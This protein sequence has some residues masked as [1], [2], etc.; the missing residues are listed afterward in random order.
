M[1]ISRTTGN[2]GIGTDDP[3]AKLHV[4]GGSAHIYNNIPTSSQ[5]PEMAGQAGSANL[6]F[7]CNNG[8]GGD[9]NGII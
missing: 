9:K 4:Q 8:P 1:R 2:V 5:E 3:Q 7:D 6:Y